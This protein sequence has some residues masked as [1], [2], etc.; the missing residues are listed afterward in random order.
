M[1]VRLLKP[2]SFP[3]LKFGDCY[4]LY[5]I[6][7]YCG[8]THQHGGGTDISS[9]N[10]MLGHRGSHCVS[11]GEDNRGYVLKWMEE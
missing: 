4:T 6:C 2:R 10:D 8:K 11:P 1:R 9:I 5:G 3:N 7:P